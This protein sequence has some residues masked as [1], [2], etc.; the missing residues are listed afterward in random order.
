MP[1]DS[2]AKH[3]R[4]HIFLQGDVQGFG[5][6]PMVYLLAQGLRLGG[7]VR[8]ADPGLEIEIEGRPEQIDRFLSEFIAQ[9]PAAAV[10]TQKDVAQVPCLGSPWFEILPDIKT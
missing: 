9:R 5:F 2:I 6:R 8:N 10:V 3:L 1:R 4:L 7:W